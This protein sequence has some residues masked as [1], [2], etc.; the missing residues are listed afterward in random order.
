MTNIW[1]LRRKIL[2]LAVSVLILAGFSTWFHPHD[3]QRALSQNSSYNAVSQN[4]TTYSI[5]GYT[6]TFNGGNLVFVTNGQMSFIINFSVYGIHNSKFTQ[7]NLTSTSFNRIDNNYQNTV[8]MINAYTEG[9]VTF[10]FSSDS[11]GFELDF[12]VPPVTGMYI[13]FN[14]S[15]GQAANI[16]SGGFVYSHNSTNS[17]EYGTYLVSNGYNDWSLNYFDSQTNSGTLSW[18]QLQAQNHI[19]YE[20]IGVTPT[21]D[22]MDLM[23]GPYNSGFQGTWT[24][25]GIVISGQ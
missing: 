16:N 20:K 18:M 14:I 21:D 1:P 15:I 4:I 5:D 13:L 7:S 19:I 24:Y 10:I 12:V 6:L 17:P 3:S 23:T 2:V 11:N 25:S 8:A 22:Y 9:G